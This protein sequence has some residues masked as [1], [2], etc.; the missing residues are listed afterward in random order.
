MSR[1]KA[2]LGFVETFFGVACSIAGMLLLVL[3]VAQKPPEV[4]ALQF[5]QSV[6]VGTVGTIVLSS[7][8][9][10]FMTALGPAI[11]AYRGGGRDHSSLVRPHTS[12]A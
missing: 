8:A 6:G 7:L 10:G 2:A 4:I 1:S 11:I 5:A 12:V 3:V 9:L